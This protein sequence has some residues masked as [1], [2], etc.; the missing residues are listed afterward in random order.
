[1]RQTAK[2][3]KPRAAATTET[4]TGLLAEHVMGWDIAPDRFLIGM[5]RW[6]PRS[7]FQP[8]E[9]IQDAFRVLE[10]VAP[11]QY[12]MGAD[13]TSGFWV[14]VRIGGAVGEA[15]GASKPQVIICA[16]TRALGIEVQQGV[17]DG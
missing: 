5:R 16:I 13:K 3:V 9:R 15:Q 4:L 1:M 12:M 11:Q 17:L 10:K 8:T 6:L 2:H 7:R 14:Q